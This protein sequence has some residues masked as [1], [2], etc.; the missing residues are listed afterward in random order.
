MSSIWGM[1]AQLVGTPDG[2]GS[3]CECGRRDRHPLWFG[4]PGYPPHEHPEM[5]RVLCAR[6]AAR[7]MEGESVG[8]AG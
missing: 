6:C 3:R 8:G 7:R 2:A 4:V 5:W 1:G